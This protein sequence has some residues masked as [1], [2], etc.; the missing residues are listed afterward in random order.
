MPAITSAAIATFLGAGLT[1][2]GWNLTE[3]SVAKPL[4]DPIKNRFESILGN[5]RR[6]ARNNLRQAV[7]NALESLDAPTKDEN[8][9]TAFLLQSGFDQLTGTGKLGGPLRDMVARTALIIEAPDPSQV[10]NELYRALNWPSSQRPLLAQ[11]LYALRQELAGD[12]IWGSLIAYADNISV[13]DYLSLTVRGLERIEACVA[14]LNSYYGLST[15]DDT[16]ALTSYLSH[17]RD[18]HRTLSFV[19]VTPSGRDSLVKGAELD[20]VFVPLQVDD[21][22]KRAE[23]MGHDLIDFENQ[24]RAYGKGHSLKTIENVLAEHEVFLL[25]GDPGSGKTTLLRHLALCFARGEAK[26]RLAW[27]GDPLLPILIPLRNFGRYLQARKYT[28]IAPR[29]LRN[30]IE[31]HFRDNEIEFPPNFFHNRL[32]DGHCIV[33]FDGLDEVADRSARTQ[34]AQIVNAFIKHH[35]GKGNRFVLSS[36]P[37]G[38][39]EVAR[40][41]P[42]PIVCNVQPLTPTGR[43]GL[44]RKLI[45]QFGGTPK[46]Q[47]EDA[48]E[49][50]QDIH[51]RTRLDELTRNPLFCTTLLL[52]YKYR[53][54]TLPERRVDVYQE[55]VKLMLGF[56][57][58]S[59][60]DTVDSRELVLMTGTT[61]L[62]YDEDDAIAMKTRALIHLAEWMQQQGKTEVTRNAVHAELAE[63]F[64]QE[65]GATLAEKHRWAKGFLNVAHQRSGLYVEQ[66]PETYAFSHKNFLEYLAATA[67]VEQT[68]AEM[69]A[70]IVAHAGDEWWHE[71][72]LLAAAHP[73][74]GSSPRRRNRFIQT[75]LDNNLLVLAGQCAVDAGAR[76]PVPMR[77][78]V[79]NQ[80]YTCMTDI[81]L[82]PVERFA[83]AQQWDALHGPPEDINRWIRCPACGDGKIDLYAA[84]YPVTNAQFAL[85]MAAD[86]YEEPAYWGGEESEAWRWRVEKHPNYRGEEAVTAPRY[87]RHADFGKERR[88][89][90]IVGV[91][92]YEAQAYCTWFS[93]LLRRYTEEDKTLVETERDLVTSL[94][95]AGIKQVRLPSDAEW[96]RIAGGEQENRYPWD[97]RAVPITPTNAIK[98]ITQRANV[99]ESNI[100]KTSPVAMHPL[101]ASIPFGLI[102]ISGNVWEWSNTVRN[103]GRYWLRGGAWFNSTVYARVGARIFSYPFS[104]VNYIGFRVVASVVS[105]S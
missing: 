100:G 23:L 71:V 66:D 50:L 104:S 75:L 14:A 94:H 61:Q 69:L 99:L 5:N 72:I 1:Q 57:D 9:L 10:P 65:E 87:W 59:R 48:A 18:K 51:S 21:P 46:R 8:K 55:L 83:A 98:T 41:L 42:E 35:R 33:L 45:R 15:I 84:K 40:Y 12:E 29:P 34:V 60:P 3:D 2:I 81:T 30:F 54:A 78:K 27:E 6:K 26:Q 52:V 97:K 102:D 73:G 88:G 56:W 89:N 74:L 16:T 39:D 44:I 49:L 92:W 101:G 37:K 38:Y 93:S 19:F 95:A 103:D 20:A 96:V 86:G 79:I 90:P 17:V 67:L 25:R 63:Y 91:S 36:R 53:G 85:F 62:V 47:R 28:N 7:T 22:S 11:F 76:L 82:S 77:R 31:Q 24:R 80:L 68:E 64:E 13:R 105:G 4:L 43:D 32:Q 70:T 58:M